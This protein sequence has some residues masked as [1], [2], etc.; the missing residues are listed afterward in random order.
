M[1][2]KNFVKDFVPPIILRLGIDYLLKDFKEYQTYSQAM[3]V[4]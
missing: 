2:F 4:Y 1:K 3:N